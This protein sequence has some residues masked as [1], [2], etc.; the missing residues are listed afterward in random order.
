MRPGTR[1]SLLAPVGL[2]AGF[3]VART[4]GRR[5]LGG[6]LFGVA[7][8]VCVRDWARSAGL[9]AAGLLAGLY[10]AAMGGS[11]PLAKKVGAWPSVL[12]VSGLV[13]GVS[14]LLTRRSA[15]S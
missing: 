11:H 14:A 1:A 8:L 3:V 5:E 12:G 13:G 2:L 6:V 9:P 7:G 10:A 4:T 15:G